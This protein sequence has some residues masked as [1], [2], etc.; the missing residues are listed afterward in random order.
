MR[1]SGDGFQVLHNSRSSLSDSNVLPLLR[2]TAG[3]NREPKWIKKMEQ[4][5]KS[6]SERKS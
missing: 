3:G 5:I 2:A 1:V 4:R 6:A